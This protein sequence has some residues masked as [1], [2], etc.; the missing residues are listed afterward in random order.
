MTQLG[1]GTKDAARGLDEARDRLSELLRRD[2]EARPAAGDRMGWRARNLT[3]VPVRRPAGTAAVVGSALREVGALD[4]GA[5]EVALV[6]VPFMGRGGRALCAEAG[7]GWLDLSGNADVDAPGVRI[8]VR[9]EPNRFGRS[10]RPVSLFSPKASRI[11]H[12]FLERVG[13]R[14]T[15]KEVV[16]ATGLDKGQ[17]SKRVRGL[18][19]A[20]LL[21]FDGA[22]FG[23][24]DPPLLLAAWE[25]VYAAEGPR[26]VL[27]VGAGELGPRAVEVLVEVLEARMGARVLVGGAEAARLHGVAVGGSGATLLV[28]TLPEREVLEELGVEVPGAGIRLAVPRDLGVV[29]QGHRRS[30]T[31]VRFTTATLAYLELGEAAWAPMREALELGWGR[32]GSSTECKKLA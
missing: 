24:L 17:V 15:Q 28:E 19:E 3:F 32:E 25:E 31:G 27:E 23:V 20:E 6:V 11:A 30:P 14:L 1:E 9:G 13:E 2:L 29:W 22:R 21:D 16:E 12:L 8:L 5:R 4:L 26:E 7:V 18:E 10:G